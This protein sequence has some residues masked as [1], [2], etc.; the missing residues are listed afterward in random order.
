MVPLDPVQASVCRKPQPGS[1]NE[2]G[3]YEKGKHSP[4][5]EVEL[6]IAHILLLGRNQHNWTGQMNNSVGKNDS[7]APK[8]IVAVD[9]TEDII[10][11]EE[12]TRA[13]CRL[14]HAAG[15]YAIIAPAD[16]A[17]VFRSNRLCWKCLNECFDVVMTV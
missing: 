11:I 1:E 13:K 2:D 12:L 3:G 4:L 14:C 5:S 17:L 15:A 16:E 8:M 7:K 10:Y 9:F 6:E